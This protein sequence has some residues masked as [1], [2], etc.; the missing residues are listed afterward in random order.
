MTQSFYAKQCP[1][2]HSINRLVG[3][4]ATCLEELPKVCTCGELLAYA[5]D[6]VFISEPKVSGMDPKV[7]TVTPLLPF[8]HPAGTL[9]CCYGTVGCTKGNL[10]AP[11][12]D[13]G[14]LR[15][16]EC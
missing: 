1:W 4:K 10:I 7:V 8:Q 12:H 11:E 15:P 16:E 2:P 6:L 3:V 14:K 5:D 13:C 9:M